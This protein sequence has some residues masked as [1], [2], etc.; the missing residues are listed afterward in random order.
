MELVISIIA[1]ALSA[2]AIFIN[3]WDRRNLK[4]KSKI[5]SFIL[6]YY[7]ATYIHDQLPTSQI[8][9]DKIKNETYYVSVEKI[10]YFLIE[11]NNE[12]KIKYSTTLDSDFN[13]IRWFPNLKVK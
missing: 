6:T 4:I 11:L 7:S 9:I 12:G 5:F 10:K 8:V 13:S 3:L 2:I 1:A